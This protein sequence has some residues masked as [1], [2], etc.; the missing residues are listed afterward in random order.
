MAAT[1]T[2]TGTPFLPAA[3][4]LVPASPR[5]GL[6]PRLY[7]I[8]ALTGL[9]AYGLLRLD[10][11]VR[12]G[13]AAIIL[14]SVLATQYACTRAWRLPA[15]DARSAL[16]S[17]L[18]LCLLLRTSWTALAVAGAV[19][20]VASKFV[21]RV[22]G[23]HVFNPTNVAIVA[24]LLTG[25]AWVSPGQWGSAAFFGFLLACLGGIVVNRASR[26][27]VTLTFLAAYA[28]LVFARSAWLGEPMTI[29]IH[30]LQNG[31]LLIFAFFMISDPRT[32]PDRRAGRVIFAL[33]VALGAAF[34]QF[35]LF[36]TNGLLWSLALFAPTVPLIDW[37]LPAAPHCWPAAPLRRSS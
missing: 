4:A 31:A 10:L 21:I 6:D 1:A 7:Q 33:L 9:L 32:T 14:I 25:Q 13:R 24:L 29:P 5:G 11:E 22:R 8:A 34:V 27:D 35:R 23:K 17:G 19:L 30:R 26:S 28:G 2:T 16:I 15:F 12:P 3:A 18:S 37:L 20:A 36:R